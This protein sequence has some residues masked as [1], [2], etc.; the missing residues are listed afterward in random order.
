MKTLESNENEI[1]QFLGYEHVERIDM[2][3]VI[4]RLQ[5]QLEQRTRKI[6]GEG[7]YEKIW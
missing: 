5:I 7:L 1:Y 4:E 6:V 3:K 2:K